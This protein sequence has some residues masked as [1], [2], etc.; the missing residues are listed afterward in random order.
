MVDR[1]TLPFDENVKQVKEI[2]R[3]AHISGVSVEAELG[4]LVERNQTSK[5]DNLYLTDPYEAREFVAQT[6]VDCLAVAIGTAH[7]IY[8]GTPYLDFDRLEKI[9]V[10]TNIP[11]VLHGGSFTGDEALQR[12]AK[13][14]ICKVNLATELFNAGTQAMR[15]H[16]ASEPKATLV[17]AH[18]AASA[19]YKRVLIRYIRLFDSGNKA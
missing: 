17:S 3:I 16:L 13:A 14:G 5:D 8:K 9:R 4:Q 19:G 2:A 11:L 15:A 6:G 7:G 1:S 18:A 12:A 10:S